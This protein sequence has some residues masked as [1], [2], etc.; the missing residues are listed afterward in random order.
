MGCGLDFD[1][2]RGRLDGWCLRRGFGKSCSLPLA[3]ATALGLFSSA[4]LAV[5]GGLDKFDRHARTASALQLFDKLGL[6]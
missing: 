4:F 1:H 2:R 3:L 5:G 6:Q